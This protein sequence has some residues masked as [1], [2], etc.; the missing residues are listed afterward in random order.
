[1]VKKS[2]RSVFKIMVFHACHDNVS[3][4]FTWLTLQ[5]VLFT[6]LINSLKLMVFYVLSLYHVDYWIVKCIKM[7]NKTN[8]ICTPTD[9][10][11]VCGQ[12]V[13]SLL[14][15]SFLGVLKNSTPCTC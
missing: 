5:L 14:I 7:V 12:S 1:M 2:Y 11:S 9:V 3:M 8:T 10:L 15:N 13:V 6:L 4:F